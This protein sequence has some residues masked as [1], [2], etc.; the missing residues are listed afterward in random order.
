MLVQDASGLGIILYTW[1]RKQLLLFAQH[2]VTYG[3]N[4]PVLLKPAF[5]AAA[6]SCNS[7]L[8]FSAAN[9]ASRRS[10]KS[11]YTE[12]ICATAQLCRSVSILAC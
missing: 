7:R 5:A 6:V 12:Y 2:M 4:P 10:E 8:C 9:V 11:V 3:I 1:D